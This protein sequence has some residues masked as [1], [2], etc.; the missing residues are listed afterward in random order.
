MK[1]NYSANISFTRTQENEENKLVEINIPITIHPCKAGV[2]LINS[3][4]LG[5]SKNGDK[6]KYKKIAS[7]IQKA[8]IASVIR[9]HCSLFPFAFQNVEMESLLIGNLRAVIRYSLQNAQP[10]CGSN[11]PK[12]YLAGYSAG[13]S[14][15][16]AVASEFPQISKMLLISPST[17]INPSTINRGLSNY[18]GE[19]YITLGDNDYVIN[20]R[21]A[22]NLADQA[23]KSKLKKLVLIPDCDHQFSG[24][25]NEEMFRKAYLWAF[26]NQQ[27]FP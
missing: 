5:G 14:T 13:A 17:D 15:S 19:L 7:L 22:Q 8:D 4:G 2:I 23:T 9:Y 6:S 26:N 3:H 27:P 20:P 1:D 21:T 18:Q 12:L 11:E 10:L 25:K 24:E 16:A